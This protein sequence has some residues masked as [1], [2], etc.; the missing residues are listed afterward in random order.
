MLLTSWINRTGPKTKKGKVGR[1]AGTS[2]IFWS[3]SAQIRA[4]GSERSHSVY[5]HISYSSPRGDGVASDP[6]SGG[7]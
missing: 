4:W 6:N 2:P 7:G 5:N 3:S 1:S